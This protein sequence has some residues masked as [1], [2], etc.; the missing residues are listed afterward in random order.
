V[1]P[2]ELRSIPL[3]SHVSDAKLERLAACSAEV[4]YE[5][6][7]RDAGRPGLRDVGGAMPMHMYFKDGRV[8]V[9]WR[10]SR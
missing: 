8:K 1:T 7:A 9:R 3:P 4:E 2:D 6:G 10:F 5:P